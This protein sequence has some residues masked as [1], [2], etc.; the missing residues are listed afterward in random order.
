MTPRAS[1]TRSG[2]RQEL[3]PPPQQTTDIATQE[4]KNLPQRQFEDLR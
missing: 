3:A 2:Q 1:L 4:H